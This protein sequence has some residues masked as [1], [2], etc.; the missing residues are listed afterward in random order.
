MKRHAF[1][2]VELLVVIAIIGILIG[3]LLPAVQAA[4]EA[5]RRMS[6]SNN[7]AQL[8]LAIHHHEFNYE[9]LP[10]GVLDS[11][12]PIRNEINAGKH[13]SWCAQ[14]LPY[15]EQSNAYKKLDFD[16][17]AYAPEN[18]EVRTLQISTFQCPSNP[19]PYT[20]DSGEG[21][22]ASDY[23]GCYHDVEAPIDSD[24]HGVLFLNS[25]IRFSDIPDGT[26]HT[27]LLGEHL[28]DRDRLGWLSGTRATLRNTDSFVDESW[29]EYESKQLGSLEVGG[30]GSHHRGGANFAFTDG[31][32]RF[33]SHSIEP[34]LLQYLGNRADGEIFDDYY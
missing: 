18:A 19:A 29:E 26:T 24:N 34:S 5:A 22:A 10:S 31:S 21:W 4:R 15:I 13:L 6:C 1:T 32:V 33:M 28:G 25:K 12:G 27:I 23:A 7:L 30:F 20:Y 2:L 9:Y 11:E 16:A 8:A 3:L 17:S 14:I